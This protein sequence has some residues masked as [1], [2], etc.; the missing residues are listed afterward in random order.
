[1]SEIHAAYERSRSSIDLQTL[2]TRTLRFSALLG[3]TQASGCKP[4]ISPF[5][6]SLSPGRPSLAFVL[7]D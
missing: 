6:S 4:L 2:G 3:G 7:Q 5:F 1:M